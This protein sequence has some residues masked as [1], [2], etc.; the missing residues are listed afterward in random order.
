[1]PP[2]P[3]RRTAKQTAKKSVVKKVAARKSVAK[4]VAAKKVAI[5][6]V[7]I[8]KVAAKKV[9]AKKVAA[10][11]SAATK[12]VAR[13]TVAKK[14]AKK[15][16]RPTAAPTTR[17]ARAFR[18]V[19]DPHA[20]HAVVD[21]LGGV[22]KVRPRTAGF[23]DLTPAAGLTPTQAFRLLRPLDL[24]VLDILGYDLEL[25]ND[26]GAVL[27]PT[28]DKARLE[29]RFAFQHVNEHAEPEMQSPP[30]VQ[31]PPVQALAANSSRLVYAV[32]ADER[33]PFSIA[34][35][36]AAMSRLPL[37]LV[38]LAAPRPPPIIF[39]PAQ[40]GQF[41]T[42]VSALPQGIVLAR[43]EDGLVIAATRTRSPRNRLPATVNDVLASAT[44]VRI[45]RNAL[46]TEAPVDQRRF[47]P[48]VGGF[49]PLVPRP[50]P[51]PR[52]RP[53]PVLP[54]APLPG[55]TA[56]EA[57]HRLII[58]PSSLEGFT[59]ATDAQ[60]APSDPDRVELWHSRLGVRGL[61]QDDN[62]IID[63][64]ANRQKIVR[65]VWTR[66]LDQPPP[67]IVTF[68]ASLTAS[69][70]EALV[71]QTAD[72]RIATPQPVDADRLYLSSL[73]AYLDLHGVWDTK[74]YDTAGFSSLLAWDHE[75]PMG[76]DQF[77]RVVKPYYFFSL[78]IPTA[79]VI[80]TERKIKEAAD[81]QAR[82][83][84]RQFFAT[85][86]PTRSFQDRRMPFRQVTLKPSVTPNLDLTP[87]PPGPPIV[88]GSIGAHGAD[89][90]WPTVGGVKFRFL[91]DCLDWDGRRKVFHVPMLAVAAQLGTPADK[92]DIVNAYTTDP[93]A[94]FPGEGQDIAYAESTKPGETAMESITLRFTG[95]PGNPGDRISTPS[96]V[97]A[98]VIIPAMRHLSPDAGPV[99]VA[100]ATSY[101]NDGF[102]GPNADTQ[103]FLTLPTPGQIVFSQG[104]QSSGGFVRPDL[105]V[106][107]LSRSLGA[108]GRDVDD[109]VAAPPDQKFDPDK[110]LKGVLAELPKLFGLFEL[111]DILAAIGLGGAP[112]FITESLDQIAGLLADL[113]QLR[114][115][116]DD[117]IARLTDQAANAA[118]SALQAQAQAAKARLDTVAGTVGTHVDEL[119]NAVDA[120]MALDTDSDLPA[121]TAAVTAPLN[122]LQGL[123]DEVLA[124]TREESLPPV[125]K[126]PLERLGGALQPLLA[127]GKI[128]QTIAAIASFVN[129]LD[130]SGLSVR[131]R[132]EWRPPMTNFPPGPADDALFFVRSDG[133]VL[134]IEARASGKDGVS[135]DALAQLS[136]FG[137]NLFPGAPLIKLTFDRLA[138]RAASGR[139]AEVDVVF[140]GMEFVGVLSFIETLK[141][142]I[143][144]DGFSDP[145]YV[146]VSS[147]GVKAGFD[148]GLPNVAVGV[149]SLENISLGADVRV[150]FLGDVVT[151]GFYFCTRE[152]PFRLTVMMIGGGGFVGIRLSP[153]GL[154]L[155]EMSLEAGASLSVDL[156]VASGS[157]SVMV[158]VYLKLE[159]DKGQ[160][161][162]YFRIRGEVDVLHLISASIT[163]E[164]S[165]TYEFDTGKM[166][167]RASIDIEVDVFFFSFSVSVSCERRLAGSNGD[168]TFAEILGVTT[169][170]ESPAWDDYCAAFAGA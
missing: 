137:L 163:L 69:D 63:E 167:G 103:V 71:R 18:F 168:P 57:P 39:F 158:G 10:R 35:V 30:P 56:I 8:K 85:A 127:A 99:T 154:V 152:K 102:A 76:R 144:F 107:G 43:T 112:K 132:Y 155:L 65:A 73:G 133:F 58:S 55:E 150:P 119:V 125:V 19:I 134:S 151:V 169:T 15:A 104:T 80:I 24:V 128:L 88:A 23:G 157:V 48:S 31:P 25:K 160:L 91:L 72:P 60:S 11:K 75:A 78:G 79:L 92:V 1:M 87:N 161:T 120:L 147:D 42:I 84:Q 27:L 9:A 131:A 32:A 118:T 12:A 170:G 33:I 106:R 3:R 130:P 94:P 40:P 53:R 17:P 36:L 66:D 126:A 162:G 95:E 90:F 38:P 159:A 97:N 93:E 116:V 41:D 140:N 6:K 5:K 138:F 145:P 74:P 166:V 67:D 64:R 86:N 153:K 77:V 82:L 123:V 121:V 83:Y 164:L 156:G 81:P 20:L 45:A 105:P 135:V 28:S 68:L 136:D 34:G 16:I 114:H 108:V 49:G 149:F 4:K 165:L 37:V 129:G 61:D 115:A 21:N 14:T 98:D 109:L 101:L 13:K 62:V 46:V 29:V 59:H 70:R 22:I 139:K 148:L 110:F 50:M 124:I 142:L 2:Q 47:R 51:R 52:P 146:D 100:Y 143:P 117:G 122:A 113:D 26:G 141:E 89:L 54:R 7:A 111:T 96:L 44:A